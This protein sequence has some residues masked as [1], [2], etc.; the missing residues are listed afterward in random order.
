MILLWAIFL[1]VSLRELG[2]TVILRGIYTMSP[3]KKE[4]I[5]SMRLIE[6]RQRMK[7]I[8][9]ISDG[10]YANL[11]DIQLGSIASKVIL[12]KVKEGKPYKERPQGE[13]IVLLDDDNIQTCKCSICGRMVDI[14][15]HK[16]DKFPYCHCGADMRGE[17]E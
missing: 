4:V 7:L 8:I 3:K 1:K 13:W 2:H 9:E 6:R 15:G 11:A 17:E 16:F 10:M 5:L 14:A 12:N